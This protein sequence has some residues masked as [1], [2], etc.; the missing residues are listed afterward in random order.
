MG[1]VQQPITYYKGARDEFI[2]HDVNNPSFMGEKANGGWG[3]ARPPP[4]DK[5]GTYN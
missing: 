3:P 4:V 5:G 1:Q 2:I